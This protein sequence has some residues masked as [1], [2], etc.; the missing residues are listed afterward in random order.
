MFS[1]LT[2]LCIGFFQCMWFC[3][4]LC[5]CIH[6]VLFAIHLQLQYWCLGDNVCAASTWPGLDAHVS[7]LLC[8]C[9]SLFLCRFAVRRITWFVFL[10]FSLVLPLLY[11]LFLLY[12]WFSGVIC[13]CSELTVFWVTSGFA[14]LKLLLVTFLCLLLYIWF[15]CCF[16]HSPWLAGHILCRVTTLIQAVGVIIIPTLMSLDLSFLD[17]CYEFYFMS[18]SSTL[19]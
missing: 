7:L 4:L 9:P 10:A 5:S 12:V 17:G 19:K 16:C 15:M 11:E 3:G 18:L 6:Y 2:A 14:A 8:L 13:F 1:L